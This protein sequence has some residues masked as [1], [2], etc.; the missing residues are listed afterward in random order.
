MIKSKKFIAA[1]TAASLVVVL[2]VAVATPFSATARAA[3]GEVDVASK[4]IGAA[5]ATLRNVDAAPEIKVAA[6]R[7][8][9]GDVSAAPGC[10]GQVWPNI[11]A[12]CLVAADGGQVHKVSAVYD[13][14]GQGNVLIRLPN[15]AR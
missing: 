9:Q 11:S 14:G 12:D 10:A 6:E 8:S 3:G 13:A 7:V 2:A 1:A 4:R 5:F 15:T